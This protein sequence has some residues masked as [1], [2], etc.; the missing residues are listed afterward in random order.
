[1]NPRNQRI[2]SQKIREWCEVEHNSIV[3]DVGAYDVNGTLRP[4]IPDRWTY[5]G[6]DRVDGPNV[7]VVMPDDYTIPVEFAD[8]IISA[9]CFQYV[10][11]PFKLMQ[12]INDKLPTGGVVIICAPRKETE[13][14]MGLP[15]ELSPNLDTGFDCWRYLKG[16]MEALLEDSGFDVLEVSY[17][18]DCCWGIGSAR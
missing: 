10:R 16:G 3:I 4:A 6:V 5:I 11:N 14:L 7:D 12:E 18:R 1:M 15:A 9:S 8:V 13:G 2:M 17:D